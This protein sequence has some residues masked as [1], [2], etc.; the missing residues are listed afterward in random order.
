MRPFLSA[1][2]SAALLSGAVSAKADA[3]PYANPGTVAPTTIYTA[4]DTGTIT[5]Y[6]V[7][8]GKLSGG[9]ELFTD[10]IRLLDLTTGT[11]TGWL[12]NSQTTTTGTSANFGSVN[13][14]DTL[15]FELLV[16]D[17]SNT[18][19]IFSSDPA[20]SDDKYNHAYLTQFSGGVLNGAL[21]PAGLYAGMED[22]NVLTNNN[23]GNL[24][25]VDLTAVFQNVTATPA[26]SP[27]P[28][29]TS[30]VLLGTGILGAAGT[31]R[32]RLTR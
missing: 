3:I 7:K 20:L 2:L 18:L 31:I 8:G 24:D 11:Q 5:G 26:P 4:T 28:E 27:T 30:L 22:T 23:P 14:G 17:L 25:Y 1:A 19:S 9:G 29:P 6:F 13:K 15:V 32:R 10:S 12:F 21:F 16:Q